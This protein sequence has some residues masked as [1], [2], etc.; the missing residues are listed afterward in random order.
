MPIHQKPAEFAQI[1]TEGVKQVFGLMP[2]T[3]VFDRTEAHNETATTVSLNAAE[4]AQLQLL[5]S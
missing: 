4:K 2:N 3:I 5:S 1:R